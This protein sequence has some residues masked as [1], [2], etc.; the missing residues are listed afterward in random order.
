MSKY[1][2]TRIIEYVYEDVDYMIEDMTR[3]KL[4]YVTFNGYMSMRSVALPPM[5]ERPEEIDLYEV[6]RHQNDQI[7]DLANKLMI[8]KDLIPEEL[9]KTLP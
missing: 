5:K 2:V 7:M 8:A 4:N 3:W 9:R 1:R 6:L